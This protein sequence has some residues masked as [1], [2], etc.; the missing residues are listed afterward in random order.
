MSLKNHNKR[1]PEPVFMYRKIQG[2]MFNIS[3]GDSVGH[4]EQN[5]DYVN[6]CLI[7][8]GY[9]NIAVSISRPNSVRFLFVGLDEEVSLQKKGR[10]TR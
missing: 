8:N 3:G 5:K 6:M 7:L 9:R 4:C 1:E 2:K 10:Y